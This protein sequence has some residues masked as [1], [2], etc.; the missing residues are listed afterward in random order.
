MCIADGLVLPKTLDS[1]LCVPRVVQSV[2]VP[3]LLITCI[4]LRKSCDSGI[5]MRDTLNAQ[6]YPATFFFCN[7]QCVN[8]NV[9]ISMC[10]AP[11]TEYL[12]CIITRKMCDDLRRNCGAQCV[13]SR[14][15]WIWSH[16]K[17]LTKWILAH[18][19]KI[20]SPR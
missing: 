1:S 10:R 13:H 2:A 14:I 18:L 19:G 5:L 6:C 15:E 12:T 9:S 17:S 7:C 4:M 8:V 3:H 11:C 20:S 16:L